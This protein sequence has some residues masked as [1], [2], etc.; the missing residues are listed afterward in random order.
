MKV[1]DWYASRVGAAAEEPTRLVS[2][3]NAWE[4]KL[5]KDK[6]RRSLKSSPK[7]KEMRYAE[8]MQAHEQGRKERETFQ[9]EL[10]AAQQKGMSE[11][12]YKEFILRYIGPVTRVDHLGRSKPIKANFPSS[13]PTKHKSDYI[14]HSIAELDDLRIE[15]ESY[16]KDID[17]RIESFE[18][19]I[20]SHLWVTDDFV[21][22]ASKGLDKTRA[23]VEKLLGRLAEVVKGFE[24]LPREEE[25]LLREEK[26]P[27][28][29][30]R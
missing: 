18:D 17:Q 5:E 29:W 4:G 11:A 6:G 26:R 28:I 9:K 8:E 2:I 23:D 13:E 7:T 3:V 25:A 19:D 1:Y 16:K 24:E 20:R 12:E 14:E 30:S 10:E 27:S 15:M 22:P 21:E